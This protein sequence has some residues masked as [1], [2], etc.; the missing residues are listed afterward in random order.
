[1]KKTYQVEGM[2]CKSCEILI[3]ETLEGIK[4]VKKAEV[5]LSKN[6]L[7]IESEKEISSGKLNAI[8]K[9]NGYS[10]GDLKAFG[11]QKKEGLG[12]MVP[13]IGIILLFILLNKLGLASFLKINSQ[14]SLI[15][16]FI[17]WNNCRIF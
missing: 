4:G 17:F 15:T 12:W 14:S 9:N 10:F 7:V 5:N 3:E 16:I 8:F 1:M 11:G 13:T 2:H 6:E